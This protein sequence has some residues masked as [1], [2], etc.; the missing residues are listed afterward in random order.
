MRRWW[1]R[2]S[3]YPSL[4]FRA[5]WTATV[6]VFV[7][8]PSNLMRR[9]SSALPHP[10]SSAKADQYSLDPIPETP[11]SPRIP[12]RARRWRPRS[13]RFARRWLLECRWPKRLRKIWSPSGPRS[14]GTPTNW[15]ELASKR[16][17]S[18]GERVPS[19]A[20]RRATIAPIPGSGGVHGEQTGSDRGDIDCRFGRFGVARQSQCGRSEGRRRAGIRKL[21]WAELNEEELDGVGGGRRC[22]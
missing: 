6:I 21:T 16:N 3:P 5:H 15:R 19:A 10:P 17:T 14:I 20:I 13:Q 18:T 2:R 12:T 8:T 9:F 22:R 7:L 1:G 11:R 4:A